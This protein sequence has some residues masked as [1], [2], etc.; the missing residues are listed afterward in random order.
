MPTS[1]FHGGSAVTSWPSIRTLAGLGLVKPAIS[2]SRVVLPQPEGPRKAKNSPGSI[3]EV[4]VLQDVRG[5]RR[6]D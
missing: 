4:D 5:R 6:R 2:R 1:R 3:D